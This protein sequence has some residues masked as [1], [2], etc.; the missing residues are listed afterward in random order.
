MEI[1]GA[2]GS[3]KCF[4]FSMDGISRIVAK[5]QKRLKERT[6]GLRENHLGPILVSVLVQRNTQ[7]L[8]SP[9]S[10]SSSFKI[11]AS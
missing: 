7:N 4:R 6:K 3:K 11:L 8:C 9:N 5:R 2:F 1:Y 10:T